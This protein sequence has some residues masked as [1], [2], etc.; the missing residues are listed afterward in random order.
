MFSVII[1]E[2]SMADQSPHYITSVYLKGN[3]VIDKNFKKKLV[4]ISVISFIKE[5][6]VKD[7]YPSSQ[8]R[9]K[10][11]HQQLSLAFKTIIHKIAKE[12]KIEPALIKAVIMVES[13]FNPNAVSKCGARGLM[14]LMPATATSLGVVDSFDPEDN[15]YGGTLYL[16]TLIDKFN[17]NIKLGLAAY[18][19]GSRKVKNFGGV[20]PFK[21]TRQY[22]RKVFKY[23][24]MYKGDDA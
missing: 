17:G 2:V 9:K 10:A 23:H 12:F 22:L 19:A 24:Q 13:S 1:V 15:I 5:S 8:T 7:P 4:D 16:K 6:V 21:Q 20:P 14:Q 3:G 11:K 18:N